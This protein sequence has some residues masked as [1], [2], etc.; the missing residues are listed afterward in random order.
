MESREFLK[1][2]DLFWS[3]SDEELSRIL[4]IIK[5]ES[6]PEGTIILE[7]GNI[8]RALYIIKEGSVKVQK[9]HGKR[10]KIIAK[11]D[12]GSYFGEMSLIDEN[13]ISATVVATSPTTCLIIK[14]EDL[15]VLLNDLQF[16]NRLLW[17]FIKTLN[18][19]LRKTSTTL[20][21]KPSR[22]PRPK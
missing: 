17:G 9:R 2:I 14:K 22:K 19:R 4:D 3:F 18:G 10:S 15:N 7:E 16:A 6:F 21:K 5:T 8:G 20:S 12:Q 1:E 11:L 13:P